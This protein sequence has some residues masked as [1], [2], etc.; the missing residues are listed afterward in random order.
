MKN[1]WVYT[2]FLEYIQ[3]SISKKNTHVLWMLIILNWATWEHVSVCLRPMFAPLS[4]EQ[5]CFTFASCITPAFKTWNW[6]S[7]SWFCPIYRENFIVQSQWTFVGGLNVKLSPVLVEDW[8]ETSKKVGPF[9]IKGLS[10]AKCEA[11]PWIEARIVKQIKIHRKNLQLRNEIEKG[12]V[13]VNVSFLV[14]PAYIL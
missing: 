10:F 4:C 3:E 12:K 8:Q 13:V 7:W 5:I 1:W 9:L 2:S 6:L 14:A 11:V